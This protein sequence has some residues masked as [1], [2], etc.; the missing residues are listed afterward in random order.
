MAENTDFRV[1]EWIRRVRDEQAGL[2]QGKSNADIIAFF[3]EAG[4]AARRDGESRS[5]EI[6]S[7]DSEEE[8]NN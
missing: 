1:L 7:L 5:K 6:L 2:L 3:S 4:G 8:P